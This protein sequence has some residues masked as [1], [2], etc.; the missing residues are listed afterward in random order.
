MLTKLPPPPP[1][2]QTIAPLQPKPSVITDFYDTGTYR[3]PMHDKYTP[4]WVKVLKD[5]GW[6]T[7]VLLID[8]ET[9]FDQDYTLDKMTTEEYCRDP[10]FEVHGFGIDWRN[11]PDARC[12]ETLW[13][14]GEA[15]RPG[16]QRCVWPIAAVRGDFQSA[17]SASRPQQIRLPGRS[18]R[19]RFE[20][21]L[22]P[23]VAMSAHP[24]SFP[25]PRFH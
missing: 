2:R 18:C 5:K 16:V 10:R 14:D 12:A 3:M 23:W 7:D 22:T 25:A 20:S 6:P 8:F 21:R 9:Y 24:S 15:A 19:K 17:A 4:A 1:K 13:Y 11:Y